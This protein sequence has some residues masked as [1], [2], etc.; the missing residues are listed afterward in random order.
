MKQL[1]L[2]NIPVRIDKL[3]P[4]GQGIG[5]ME[6]GKKGFFWNT[7][8][9][10][11]T[12]EYEIV[13]E[14]AH[15]V[16]AISMKTERP[17]TRRLAPKDACFLSTSPWQMMDYGFELEQ[18]ARILAEQFKVLKTHVE[19]RP[20]QSD[21][22]SMYYRNKMEYALWYDPE[23]GRNK[24]AFHRRGTH[25][26]MPIRTSS[27]EKS[28]IF[29]AAQKMVERL[30]REHKD[31]RR[32]QSLLLRC[33]QTGQV[34]GGFYEKRHPH[35][36][37]RHLT[38][39][40]LGQ[41]YSYSPNGFFQINIPVYELALKEIQKHIETNRVLDLYSGVGTIGLTVARDRDLT[42]I[43]TDKNA[44]FELQKNAENV[45]RAKPLL[46]KA[47]EATEQIAADQTVI[48]DPP[49]AGLDPKVV[50]ALL[51]KAP[52]KIIYLSCNPATQI[53][54][55][56][57]LLAKYKLRLVQPYNFFPRTPHLENLVVLELKGGH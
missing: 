13:K 11:T 23:T 6:D 32:Y 34:S 22:L 47:E 2:S 48:L 5:T 9:G 31:S 21:G 36:Q 39:E 42:L 20:V 33:S 18:K 27:I 4:T 44:F 43:E 7:L 49:R 12:V 40:V 38:D 51:E 35:P 14:K 54:D 16:E 37:F 17:S 28:E 30:T 19:I 50:E 52:Q 45:R 8:P 53:R 26:K 41:T 10:E 29:I 57:R 25:A 55:L 24:L 1:R 15:Y 56:E 3:T 46:T